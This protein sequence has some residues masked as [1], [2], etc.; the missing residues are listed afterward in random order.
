PA[1]IA[2]E[3][4]I[5][6]RYQGQ[7][8]AMQVPLPADRSLDPEAM[9]RDFEALHLRRYGHTQPGSKLE[10]VNIRAS[11]I[12]RLDHPGLA[13]FPFSDETGTPIASRDVFFADAGRQETPIFDGRLLKPGQ[14]IDGPAL[15]AEPTTTVL[16]GPSDMLRVD[17][18]NNLLIEFR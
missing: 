11:G 16:V 1:S 3:R 5:D 10:S 2:V 8:D 14:R 17:A 9:L 7:L 12:A 15:I 6:L 4:S 13:R 18:Y